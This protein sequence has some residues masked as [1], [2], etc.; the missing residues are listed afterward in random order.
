MSMRTTIRPRTALA[1]E[2]R[3]LRRQL[4]VYRER[5]MKPRRASNRMRLGL[6]VLAH[7]FAWR[8]AADFGKAER[9]MN[10]SG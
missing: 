8:E 10:I 6:V 4:A 7:C 3:F 5:Q 1:A 9:A 2:I